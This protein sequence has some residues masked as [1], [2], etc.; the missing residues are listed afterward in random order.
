MVRS[1][2][3]KSDR[4]SWSQDQMLSAVDLIVKEGKCL[5]NVASQFGVPRSTLQRK[6]NIVN[7]NPSTGPDNIF[8]GFTCTFN[9]EQ[10][11]AFSRKI[12][13]MENML[14][15]L[16]SIDMRK[17]AFQFAEKL[18]IPHHFSKETGFAGKDWLRG[19]MRRHELSL[20]KAEHT[21][22]ARANGFNKEAVQE[23][24]SLL[25]DTLKR[26]N[27]T[28]ERIYNVDETGISVV[29]KTSP[30][31]IAR[32]GKRQVGGKTVAER[33]ETVTADLCMSAGGAF[34]LPMLIYSSGQQRFKFFSSTKLYLLY[35]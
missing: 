9:A 24:F 30:K 28:P 5:K 18:Q 4:L 15:P 19:F 16:T 21:S 12:T 31:V 22:A 3:K 23:F 20:R 34:M 2:K 6:V 29:P 35:K 11:G 27:F 32:K 10:E 13:R 33:G 8:K 26:Y 1:Y 7:K 25:Q 14:I 17:L